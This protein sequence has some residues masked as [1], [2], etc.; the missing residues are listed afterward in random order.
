MPDISR[1]E[2][3]FLTRGFMDEKNRPRELG[4]LTVLED[5][6]IIEK[7]NQIILG[8]GIYFIYSITRKSYLVT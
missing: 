7:F 6:E 8:I 1:L 3:K 4:I 2:V 5:H